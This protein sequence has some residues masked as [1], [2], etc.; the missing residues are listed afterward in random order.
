MRSQTPQT[1]GDRITVALIPGVGRDLR[2]LQEQT[3]LS[4]TDLVHRAIT[5]YEFFDAQLRSGRHLVIRDKETGELLPVEFPTA[6]AEL[7]ISLA[8]TSGVDANPL[9]AAHSGDGHVF[10]SYVSEDSITVERL[11]C[12]LEKAGITVWRD[13]SSLGPGDLWK[14]TIRQAI[15]SGAFFLACFSAASKLRAKSYMN[16]EVTLAVEELRMRSRDRVWFLPVVLPGGEVPDRSIGAGE[17]LRDFN[18]AILTPET[19]STELRK[20]VQV[21][22]K[23]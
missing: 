19:W 16:E 7:K 5:S 13:R 3:N 21:I 18:Y 11:Q 14:T 1:L 12:D 8:P 4:T 10:I 2:R 15:S 9:S 22:K 17:T 23:G 6:A 20:L